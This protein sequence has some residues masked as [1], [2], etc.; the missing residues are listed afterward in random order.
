M[1]T[2]EHSLRKGNVRMNSAVAVTSELDDLEKATE[3]LCSGIQKKLQFGRS[4]VGIVCC[5]ADVAV[6]ELGRRLHERLGIEIVGMTTMA[7][8][9][10]HTGYSNMGIILTVLT[11]DDVAFSVGDTG[12]INKDNYISLIRDAYR[13]ASSRLAETSTEDPKLILLFS[14]YIPDFTA[15]RGMME[16]HDMSGGVPIFGGIAT[17]HYDLQYQKTFRNGESLDGGYVFLLISGNVRP[18]FAMCHSF[19]GKVERKSKITKSCDNQIGRVDDLTFRDYLASIMPCQQ[20]DGIVALHFQSTPFL[21][22]LPDH[23]PSE[24]PVVRA[25][26]SLNQETGAGGFL[27]QMPEGSTLSIAMLQRNNLIESCT[28]ALDQIMA[29]MAKA[30]DYTY[31]MV[32]VCSCNARHLLLADLKECESE[33]FVEKIAGLNPELNAMGFYGF[34]ELCPTG[35]DAANKSLNRYHNMSF[36]VCAF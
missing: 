28:A 5:D 9:E 33:I 10:R 36:T 25:L 7:L 23:D 6:D 20:V 3:E 13:D 12:E 15:D 27:S 2:V 31:S 26:Y 17:D 22:E 11:G 4:A 24:P 18:I 34:G 21:V 32:F 1:G 16:I 30:T 8:M 19:Y 29:G 14:P 35:K